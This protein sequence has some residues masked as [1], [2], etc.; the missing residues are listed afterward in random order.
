MTSPPPGFAGLV[1]RLAGWLR[2]Y[3]GQGLAVLGLILVQVGFA[4]VVPFGYQVIFD[5]V[6]PRRSLSALAWVMTGLLAA[7]LVY[8]VATVLQERVS[9]RLGTH[10][11]NDL[12]QR[13]FEQIQ[14]LG[15][16]LGA[17]LDAGDLVSRFATDLTVVEASIIR[18]CP[19]AS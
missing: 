11:M 1:H 13:L 4:L 12:R 5:T 16:G 7:F 6:L 10:V 18:P 17:R 9:A 3:R 8:S 19:W 14:R 2:P 15:L